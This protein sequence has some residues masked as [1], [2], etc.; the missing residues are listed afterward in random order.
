MQQEKIIVNYEGKPAYEIIFDKDFSGLKDAIISLGLQNRR[1]MIITD[2]N[3][4]KF[5]LNECIK[6]LEPVAASISSFTFD[7]GEE[8]KNLNT[9]NLVYQRL[10]EE[11]FDRYDIII[12]L[13]GGVVGDLAG[14]A[15]ATYLR[16][17]DFIQVPTTLLSM[18]DSS[19]GGKTGVDFMAY[20]N[21]I[22][23]FHQPKLVYMNL[24]ALNSLPKREFNSGMSEVIKHGLIKNAAYYKWLCDNR[25]KISLLD[26]ETLK[27]MIIRSCIIKKNVV[28]ADPKEKGERALLN[29]GHTIGHAIEKLLDFKFLHGECI[30][31]GMIAAGY[32]SYKR[33]FINKSELDDIIGLIKS[34]DLP[35]SISGLS[36]EEVYN[37]TKLDKKMKSDKIKFICLERIG[38]AFIDMTVSKDEIIEA[39]QFVL[40]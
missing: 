2:S 15:A 26:Y 3:V 6:N 4:G 33:G 32:I 7:A 12:A 36:P 31:V 35:T 38:T 29:F 24:S 34:F 21:M 20:K 28:E 17:I 10:I 13:G 18:V 40:E 37:V 27:Q 5:Y 9:V 39:V 30:A 19:I 14:F 1:F 22:G 25:D 11:K 16:G 8:S 23:A